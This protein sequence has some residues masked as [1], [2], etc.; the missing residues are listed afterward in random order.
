MLEEENINALYEQIL[1]AA[2]AIMRSEMGSMQMLH[3]DSNQLQL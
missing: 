2:I 3:P 1:Q